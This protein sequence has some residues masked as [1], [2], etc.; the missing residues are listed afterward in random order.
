MA[1]A[2]VIHEALARDQ[3]TGEALCLDRIY[4]RMTGLLGSSLGGGQAHD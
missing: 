2:S 3:A 1:R 4:P